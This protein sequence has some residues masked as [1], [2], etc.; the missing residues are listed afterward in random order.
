[1]LAVLVG[2]DDRAGPSVAVA[3]GEQT[4]ESESASVTAAGG[5]LHGERPDAAKGAM[6]AQLEPS[7]WTY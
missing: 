1:M 4:M 7:V 5:R 2:E 6:G 3:A